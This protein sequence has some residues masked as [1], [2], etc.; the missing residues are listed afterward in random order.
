MGVER[1]VIFESLVIYEKVDCVEIFPPQNIMKYFPYSL[2]C[3][4]IT[5]MYQS[6]S[7]IPRNN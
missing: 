7:P 3:A 5:N 4:L 6:I 1:Y 2:H